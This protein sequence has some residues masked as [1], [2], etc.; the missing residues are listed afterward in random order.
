MGFPSTCAFSSDNAGGWSSVGWT[1]PS[2]PSLTWIDGKPAWH[3]YCRGDIEH[4][5][6]ARPLGVGEEEGGTRQV[7]YVP[8]PSQEAKERADLGFQYF[9]LG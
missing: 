4:P 9:S 1:R 7:M 3:G 6:S 2:I 5:N 8:P